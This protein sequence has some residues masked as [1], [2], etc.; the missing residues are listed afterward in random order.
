MLA[1]FSQNNQLEKH[2]W[3]KKKKSHNLKVEI[4]AL[5]GGLTKDYKVRMQ[6]L[7]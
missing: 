3:L 2:C 6:A 1:I 5:F 4:Y 7:R